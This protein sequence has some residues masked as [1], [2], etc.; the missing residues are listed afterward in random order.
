MSTY[1]LMDLITMENGERAKSMDSVSISGMTAE[2]TTAH[3]ST[4]T[5]TATV[6]TFIRT[7][8]VM[9]ASIS[10][11]RRKDSEFMFGQMVVSTRAGGTLESNMELEP[12]STLQNHQ[13]NMVFGKEESVQNGLT[14][15]Q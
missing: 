14:S 13:L 4:T 10:L 8:C 6:F 12:T 7:V 2:S 5:C 15:K 1:G 3:G 11:T 9:M